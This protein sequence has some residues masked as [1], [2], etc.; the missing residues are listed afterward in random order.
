MKISNGLSKTV[1]T[2]HTT[3][4]CFFMPFHQHYYI[5]WTVTNSSSVKNNNIA[6]LGAFDFEPGLLLSIALYLKLGLKL[7]VFTVVKED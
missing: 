4:E 1:N 2:L 6:L 7:S 3:P 5:G